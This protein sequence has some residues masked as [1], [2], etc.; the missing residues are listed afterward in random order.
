MEI[1]INQMFW[2]PATHIRPVTLAEMVKANATDLL[3]N[4][5]PE[6]HAVHAAWLKLN[7]DDLKA[8]NQYCIRELTV[9]DAKDYGKMVRDLVL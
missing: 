9:L 7:V 1:A 4:C 3:N 6:M 5:E 2:E 8:V